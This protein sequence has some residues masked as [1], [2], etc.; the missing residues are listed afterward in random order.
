V[1]RFSK[2][3]SER[4]QTYL[5]RRLGPAPIQEL[6]AILRQSR[7]TSARLY[8]GA[9]PTTEQ[10]VALAEHYGKSFVADIFEPVVGKMDHASTDATLHRVEELLS[11]LRGRSSDVAAG[12]SGPRI[13]VRRRSLDE[14]AIAGQRSYLVDHLRHWTESHGRAGRGEVTD[15]AASTPQHRVSLALDRSDELRFAYISPASR[16]HAGNQERLIGRPIVDIYDKD[17]A[18]A[19]AASMRDV[20]SSGAPAIDDVDATVDVEPGVSMH[21]RY[22]RLVLPFRSDGERFAV[23]AVESRTLRPA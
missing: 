7:Q 10:V 1:T 11:S 23:C 19:C 13:S 16:L 22:R 18:E 15:M 3:L 6:A 2:E 8:R 9:I 5:Q 20:M 17:Y 21:L 12:N 4:C 14:L